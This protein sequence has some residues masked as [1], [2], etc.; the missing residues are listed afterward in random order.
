VIRTRAGLAVALLAA[1]AGACTAPTPPPAAAPSP[2]AEP[3][4]ILRPVERVEPREF[5]FQ[6]ALTQ[7]GLAIGQAPPGA[8]AVFLDGTPVPLAPDGR[9]LIGFGRDAKPAATVEALLPGNIRTRQTLKIA[10]RQWQIER[11]PQLHRPAPGAPENPAAAARRSAEIA[12]F[13]AAR[14]HPS[15]LMHWTERFVWPVTGRIAG[16][17]GAQRI[18]GGVPS[19]PHAGIDIAR[20]AGTPVV[21]PAGG[22]IGLASPPRFSLEGN[23]IFIDHGHGLQSFLMHLSRIDVRVGQQVRQGEIVGAVGMTGRA[24][25]PHLHWGV[26]WNETKLD[27]QLLV[28]PL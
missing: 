7:G 10:P 6:G 23:M 9:F 11:I 3:V 1:W 20:P 21:A 14:A 2:V 4:A 18:L 28:P 26:T 19:A 22:T 25:G 13:R 17:Y 8:R 16:V 12:Q 5:A 24:T 15:N 27:P